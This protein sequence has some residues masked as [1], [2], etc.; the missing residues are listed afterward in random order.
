MSSE[1]SGRPEVHQILMQSATMWAKRSTCSRA[2]VGAVIAHRGRAISSGYNGAPAGMPHC[3]HRIHHGIEGF[4]HNDMD[5]CPLGSPECGEIAAATCG[6]AVHAEAN[7]IAFAAR[8][9]VALEGSTLYTTHAPC[10]ACAQL[11]INAGILEVNY[12]HDYRITDGRVL[13][14]AVGIDIH[15]YQVIE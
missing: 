13:L 11:I 7:A 4:D 9:G 5:E 2:Q 3:D 15:Q 6:T 10:V 8:Y 12:L 14:S 1:P